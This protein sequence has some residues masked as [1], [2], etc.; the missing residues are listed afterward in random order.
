MTFKEGQPIYA[1]IADRLSDEILNGTYAP[2]SRVPGV[3]EYAALLE[4]NVNTAV[5]AYELLARREVIYQKRGM[6]YFVA[7]DAPEIIRTERRSYFCEHAMPQF[8]AQMKLLGITYLLLTLGLFLL[9]VEYAPVWALAVAAV[10]ALPI[11]GTGTIL[12]PWSLVCLLRQE[13]AKALGLLGLYAA[14]ALSRSFL[15][16]RLVG[17]QLGLDPLVTLIA[18]YTGFRLWG[19]LGMF[20]MPML[21]IT[22]ISMLPE[23]KKG[24][25]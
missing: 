4:V 12:V 5:K 1:Q 16:P 2:D 9:G 10:D 6:G 13:R 15:E 11:L 21:A 23:T 14:A 24:Q 8:F 25:S 18:L 19:L 22:V 7:T 17:R 20:L 3:R